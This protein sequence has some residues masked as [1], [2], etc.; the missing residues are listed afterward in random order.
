ML[1][2]SLVIILFLASANLFG[3]GTVRLTAPAAPVVEAVE[4]APTLSLVVDAPSGNGTSEISPAKV[5][6]P[7]DSLGTPDNTFFSA[8]SNGL[9]NIL[10]S[11]TSGTLN[12]YLDLVPDSE[13]FEIAVKRDATTFALLKASS[14]TAT[15]VSG[16]SNKVSVAISEIC[17]K[18]STL[19][20]C[21]AQFNSSDD[22][23]ATA[24]SMLYFFYS[25]T[26]LADTATTTTT[27]GTGIFYELNVSN[28]VSNS[29]TITLNSLIKG[30]SQLTAV[31]AGFAFSPIHQVVAFDYGQTQAAD[32]TYSQA[33]T[34]GGVEYILEGGATSG[35]EKIK[36][37][38]NDQAYFFSIFFLDKYRFATKFSNVVNG[39]PQNIEAL[40]EKNACFLLTAGFGGD[41]PVIDYFRSWR[42]EFLLSFT[43]GKIFVDFYYEWGPKIAPYILENPY[44]AKIVRGGA[45]AAYW[46]LEFKL[47]AVLLF[48][49]VGLVLLK[50]RDR[51]N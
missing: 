6:V 48:F 37:L 10:P 3:A 49:I 38:T 4:T 8:Y 34:L 23:V 11:I 13:F 31:Y 47:W 36:N 17:T 18:A 24:Q 20:N 27:N 51:L 2:Y 44:L 50:R 35:N 16:N 12:F 22:P 33:K 25:S 1:K 5:Y 40:L 28:N 26:D 32:R 7:I 15:A 19:L 46:T 45:Y 9:A 21:T 41:H 29:S 39:T 14:F 42:D 43:L 30:D